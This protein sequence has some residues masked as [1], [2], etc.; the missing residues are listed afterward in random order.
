MV[1]LYKGARVSKIKRF[2]MKKLKSQLKIQ[3]LFKRSNMLL[4]L[5]LFLG[6]FLRT[7]KVQ[8]LFLYGHDQDL[9]GW[10]VRD[11]VENKHLRLIGQETSTQGIF[12]GPLYYYLLIPFYLLFGMDPIGGIV[13]VTVLGI[14]S[15]FSFYWV[16]K[17]VFSEREGFIASFIYAISF[18]T[19]FNDREVVPTMPVILWSA[20]FY[21]ATHLLLN[22]KFKSG[23]FL[24]GIL[25]GL[26]W[27]LN[28]TLVILMGLLPVSIFLSKK[29]FD[30]KES[31][32]GV[33]VFFLLSLPLLLFELRHGFVQLKALYLSLTQNQHD[34]ISGYEKFARVIHLLSKNVSGLI[35][36]NF[37]LPK[38]E[39]TFLLLL[40]IFV[41][42]IR[43]KVIDKNQTIIIFL[44]GFIYLSFF[45]L[46]S[47]IVSEYY[48][49]GV[50]F[51]FIYLMTL[52]ISYLWQRRSLR[53]YGGASLIIFAILNINKF[54]TINVNKS[55]YI[56]RKAIVSEIKRDAIGREFPCVSIS[57]ITKPGYEFGYRYFFYLE[58][59]HVNRPDSGSPVYTI[60][61]P[62]NDKLFPTH[63]TFGHIGLIYP[64]YKRYTREAVDESCKGENSN[65]TDSMF[66]FTK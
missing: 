32:R 63:K 34:I 38:F 13:L 8:E 51:V 26:I 30:F 6:F 60:V 1:L 12:I 62:L 54:A 33:I 16:F 23:I 22:G 40:F 55:G 47:K 20:W 2:N 37:S 3:N 50:T 58:G 65:L 14:F 48:L 25:L 36:G 27:H 64:D 66:G 59:M 46:Y 49:N 9:A 29:K 44:W 57:Y 24:S 39:L 17:K 35:W 10:F 18:Y 41:L 5:I 42:L 28:M 61:Y 21:Y 56:E 11:V 31:Y 15:I 4:L 43:K 19:V 53:F 7:Y 52:G 45:S